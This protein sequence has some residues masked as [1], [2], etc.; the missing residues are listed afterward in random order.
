MGGTL[1]D[2]YVAALQ[3]GLADLPEDATRVGVVRTPTAW[4]HGVVD[5]NVPALGPPTGLLEETKRAKEDLKRRGICDEEAHN[6]AWERV[7][8]GD[9]YR[10]YLAESAAARGAADALSARLAD[11]ETLALVCY[12]NTAKKRCHRTIL[13]R[14]LTDGG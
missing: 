9:R 8:F 10:T 3:H 6:A 12:E 4:F 7:D 14:A 11:G 13:A 5:E 1:H 2:T